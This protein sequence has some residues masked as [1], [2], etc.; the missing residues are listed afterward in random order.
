MRRR[1]APIGKQIARHLPCLRHRLK[2]RAALRALSVFEDKGN[3]SK[4]KPITLKS[5]K[6]LVLYF[7]KNCQYD[8][9]RNNPKYLSLSTLVIPIFS[10]ICSLSSSYQAIYKRNTLTLVVF[11][12]QT[13]N[14]DLAN[15]LHFKISW[16]FIGL[17]LFIKP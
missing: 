16:T 12:Y 17:R 5:T 1:T 6:K 2:S 13:L 10:F 3:K 7:I 4:L 15:F 9:D 14:S 11:F 8:F